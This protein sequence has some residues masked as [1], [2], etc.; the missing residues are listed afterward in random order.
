MPESITQS[1]GK[2][3]ITA[4]NPSSGRPVPALQAG[5]HDEQRQKRYAKTLRLTSEQL[6]GV[7]SYRLMIVKLIGLRRNRWTSNQEQ[8]LSR[9]HC[10]LQ[11]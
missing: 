7:K 5:Q 3:D 4:M 2:P 6:V 8:T 11:V 10:R 1:H 9:S